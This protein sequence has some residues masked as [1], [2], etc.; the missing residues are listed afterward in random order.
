[1]ACD[2]DG[3]KLKTY[4]CALTIELISIRKIDLGVTVERVSHVSILLVD[5]I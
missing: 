5:P 3:K 4:R 2:G 1:M